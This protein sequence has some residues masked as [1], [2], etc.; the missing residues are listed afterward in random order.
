MNWKLRFTKKGTFVD[1]YNDKREVI[2]TRKFLGW[3]TRGWED[4]ILLPKFETRPGEKVS[5]DEDEIY[6]N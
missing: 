4:T 2:L 3:Q 5:I 6:I 1:F